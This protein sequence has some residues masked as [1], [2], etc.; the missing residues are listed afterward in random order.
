VALWRNTTNVQLTADV[1][2][3]SD[4][5]DAVVMVLSWCIDS[6]HHVSNSE[7]TEQAANVQTRLLALVSTQPVLHMVT[8]SL[9]V[10]AHGMLQLTSALQSDP[11]LDIWSSPWPLAFPGTPGNKVWHAHRSVFPGHSRQT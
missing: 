8:E 1:E 11:S 5:V 2:T 9:I 3:H 6:D 4:P 10:V 7:T